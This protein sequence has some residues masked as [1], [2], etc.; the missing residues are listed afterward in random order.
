M[1]K[2][3]SAVAFTFLLMLGSKAMAQPYPDSLWIGN[4]NSGTAVNVDKSG[5]LLRNGP[6]GGVIGYAVD[7]ANNTLYINPNTSSIVPYNLTTLTAGTSV[8]I[9]T[10]SYEDFTLVGSQIVAGNFGGSAV[11]TINPVTGTATLLFSLPFA[12]P[13]EA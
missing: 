11:N 1:Q 13:L 6:V 5:N 9:S 12:N 4:D 8:N 3:S 7:V 2:F 10:G